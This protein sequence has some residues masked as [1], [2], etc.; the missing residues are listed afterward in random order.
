M[1]QK[2]ISEI[3]PTKVSQLYNDSDYITEVPNGAI[4]EDKLSE[5]VKNKLNQTGG[6][7]YEPPV[8]GIP[9]QDLSQ[10]VQESLNKADTALQADSLTSYAKLSEVQAIANGLVTKEAHTSDIQ[11]LQSEVDRIAKT[12]PTKTSEL[13]NDSEYATMG[14]VES[15]VK[16]KPSS[17]LTSIETITEEEYNT[18][19][20]EGT[21]LSTTMYVIV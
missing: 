13:E 5:E 12:I 20:A 21:L 15:M 9:K 3:I 6:G 17:N 8:G 7:G 11:G 10:E 19:L 1:S 18:K 4:N 14:E 2:A 16:E